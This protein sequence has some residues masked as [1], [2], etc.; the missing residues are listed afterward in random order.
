MLALIANTSG[1]VTV[2]TVI[3]EAVLTVFRS[4][5]TTLANHTLALICSIKNQIV[6]TSGANSGIWFTDF[7][8]RKVI[9]LL[10][11][12]GLGI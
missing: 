3:C 9:T 2:Q 8:V 10:T 1:I 11:S 6:K 7:T 5:N 4:C 12:L